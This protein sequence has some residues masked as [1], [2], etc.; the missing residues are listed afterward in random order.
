MVNSKAI[1]FFLGIFFLIGC[2]TKMQE[3]DAGVNIEGWEGNTDFF[4]LENG[5]II[6][7]NLNESIPNN[8]F[9]CTEKSYQDFEMSLEAKLTGEGKNA[10][11]QFRSTR[12]PNHFEVIGYQCDMGSMGTRPIWG[13]LYDES[14]RK[15]FLTHP[16]ADSVVKYLD[17]K[18]WNKLKIRVEGHHVQIWLNEFQTVNYIEQDSTIK[19]SGTICLQIHSGPPA[20]AAYRNIMI[21][22]LKMEN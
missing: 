4:R 18:G 13:S 14:R 21:T 8:E 2:H 20:E 15:E 1:F 9:L 6:A 17:P 7:G 3:Q 16:P 22:E 19:T 10:G 12:I 5:V 11:V